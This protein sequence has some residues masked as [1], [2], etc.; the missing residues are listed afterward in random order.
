[1]PSSVAA[2]VLAAG[3]GSRFD[4]EVPKVLAPLHGRALLAHA[5]GAARG[6]RCNPILTVVPADAPDT[7]DEAAA[8][9]DVT[10]V[11]NPVPGLGLS[12]S[13]ACAIHHVRGLPGVSALCVALGDQPLLGPRAYDRLLDAHAEGSDLVV[14]TYD[15]RRG[16]PVLLGRTWWDAASSLDGDRGARTLLDTGQPTEIVCDGT[17]RPDDVDTLAE[18][19][20]LDGDV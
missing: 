2:V 9:P 13:L 6:S 15:G 5:L 18:L 19:Q 11:T 1:M 7:A 3:A 17:G 12:S 16:H 10:V 20:A 14:A 8:Q 4:G